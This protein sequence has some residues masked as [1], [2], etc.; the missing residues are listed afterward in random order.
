MANPKSTKRVKGVTPPP[1]REISGTRSTPSP[2][3]AAITRPPAST[4]TPLPVSTRSRSEV[5]GIQIQGRTRPPIAEATITGNRTIPPAVTVS[6]G[7]R[8]RSQI[9][10]V[11]PSSSSRNTMGGGSG[12]GGLSPRQRV[13]RKVG[14][15][16]TLR[17][18]EV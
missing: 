4:A 16:S 7:E 17:L 11:T 13:M 18:S 3:S 12:I 6:V 14:E 2:V 15:S 5:P 9:V 10:T 1:S 8:S